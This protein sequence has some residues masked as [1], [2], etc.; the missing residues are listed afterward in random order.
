MF[1]NCTHINFPSPIITSVTTTRV[2]VNNLI[3]EDSDLYLKFN[4]NNFYEELWCWKLVHL[5]EVLKL[6]CD[7]FLNLVP[8]TQFINWPQMCYEINKQKYIR[9]YL[10]QHVYF[11]FGFVF[12]RLFQAYNVRCWCLCT[13]MFLYNHVTFVSF[14]SY[15][16]LTSL[17]MYMW[18]VYACTVV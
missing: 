16:I 12:W 6:V 14:F 7:W 4:T 8:R 15:Q 3:R 18:C 13:L 17:P 9:F 1:S 5:A 2:M 11:E 10:K